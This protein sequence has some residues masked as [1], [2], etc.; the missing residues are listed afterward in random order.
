MYRLPNIFIV[1]MV[2]LYVPYAWLAG[3]PLEQIALDAGTMVALLLLG[4][5]MF[6]LR[7]IGGGDAKFIAACGLWAG[8][9]HGIEYLLYM[10]LY[11]GVMTLGLLLLRPIVA[12]ATKRFIPHEQLPFVLQRR[13]PVPYGVA[14]SAAL[15]TLISAGKIIGISLA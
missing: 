15:L 11:G 12:R 14:I 3:L 13:A 7:M 4:M 6:A 10:A 9:S 1:A 2:A 8:F 5:A